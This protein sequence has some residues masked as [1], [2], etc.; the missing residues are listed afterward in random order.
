MVTLDQKPCH[1]LEWGHLAGKHNQVL[2]I[3]TKEGGTEI[4]P[5][6]IIETHT[7]EKI[8]AAVGAGSKWS[9]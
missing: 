4:P 8:Q 5:T 3:D 2:L 9:Y 7:S 1:S 6:Q